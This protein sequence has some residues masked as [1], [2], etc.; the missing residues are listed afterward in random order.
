MLLAVHAWRGETIRRPKKVFIA[1]DV[2][3]MKAYSLLGELSG[4]NFA[5]FVRI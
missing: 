3:S 2:K 1:L 5:R 4:E